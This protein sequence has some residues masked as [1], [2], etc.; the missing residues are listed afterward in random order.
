MVLAGSLNESSMPLESRRA[1]TYTST[2]P[3]S[4]G[5]L[6]RKV[7][8]LSR[9]PILHVACQSLS[10]YFERYDPYVHD[11]EPKFLETSRSGC[12]ILGTMTVSFSES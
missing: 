8:K 2:E 4:R 12:P 6:A 11:N 3:C 7:R 1:E 5:F 9:D 10:Q